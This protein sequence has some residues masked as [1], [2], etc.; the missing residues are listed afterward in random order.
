[1]TQE[2]AP[3]YDEY[4]HARALMGVAEGVLSD[5]VGAHHW[6]PCEETRQELDRARAAEMVAFCDA[7]LLHTQRKAVAPG[8]AVTLLDHLARVR[9]LV[10]DLAKRAFGDGWQDPT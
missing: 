6:N 4:R 10:A 2:H 1:V 3:T 9:S 7:H 5:A 8:D